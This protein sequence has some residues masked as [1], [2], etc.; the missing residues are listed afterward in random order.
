MEKKIISVT[1]TMMLIASLLSF[2]N[3]SA[4]IASDSFDLHLH[5]EEPKALPAEDGL[6]RIHQINI[7][8]ADAYLLTLGETVVLVDCGSDITEPIALHYHNTPLF[9]YLGGSGIDHVDA[10]I[11]THWHNDHD[12]NVNY[13]GE[14]YGRAETVVYGP[15]PAL[16]DEL[17][18]LAAGSYQQ[19]K[20]GD[21]LNIG[22]IDLLCIS[23][24]WKEIIPGDR[25]IDSLNFIITYGKVRILF[26]GD[27]MQRTLLQRWKEEI[28]NI[29]IISFPH[30]GIRLNEVPVEVYKLVNPRLVLIPGN[31]YGEVRNF[32]IHTCYIGKNAV[33][34]CGMDGHILCTTD[35]ES[36]WY[37]T[38]VVPGTFPVGQMLPERE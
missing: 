33:Y 35:G 28:D 30:H 11:V 14:I 25:N 20:E 22:G 3:P 7:G 1:L 37:Q 17:Q 13:I 16:Y 2:L 15:S 5:T 27:Y 23:P 4:A 38:N 26:T 18:P 36:I 34:L 29:D 24:A 10:H 31:S 9:E 12:Y 21:R 19:M 6:L 8:C 32:A